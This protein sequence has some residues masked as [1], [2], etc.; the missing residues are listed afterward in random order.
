MNSIKTLEAHNNWRRGGDAEMCSPTLLGLA[1]EDCVKAAKRYELVR[2]LNAK[3]FK[4]LHLLNLN[5]ENFDAM[6][7][8]LI[9]AGA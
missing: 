5:G 8:E 1:I 7:D 2:T 3:Q 9:K 6:V 4:D